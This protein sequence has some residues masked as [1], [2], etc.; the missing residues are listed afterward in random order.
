VPR[1]E[2]WNSAAA[3]RA[4]LFEE[5]APGRPQEIFDADAWLGDQCPSKVSSGRHQM[6]ARSIRLGALAGSYRALAR[7][8]GRGPVATAGIEPE[9]LPQ[10]SGGHFP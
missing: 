9:L 3:D 1:I 6:K 10:P 5:L 7:V 4:D 8:L 2:K